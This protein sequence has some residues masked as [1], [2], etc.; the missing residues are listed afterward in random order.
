[1]ELADRIRKYGFRT[2]YERQLIEARAW[3]V[4]CFLGIILVATA[5]E[6]LGWF[7]WRRYRCIMIVAERLGEGAVRPKC[8]VD[9][10]FT[11]LA[12]GP[13]RLPTGR[14]KQTPRLSG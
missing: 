13:E 3:L 10:A 6:L 14:T 1:V 5:T 7:A 8:K 11:I 9:G 4:S 2:W 12:A